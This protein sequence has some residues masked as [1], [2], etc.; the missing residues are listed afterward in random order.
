MASAGERIED[1][2]QIREPRPGRHICDVCDPEHVWRIGMEVAIHQIGGGAFPVIADRRARAS[3]TAD[4]G[5]TCRLHQ[6]LDPLAADMHAAVDQFSVDAWSTI[7]FPGRDMD[8]ADQLHQFPV[9]DVS[10][11]R[12]SHLPGI[13]A[14]ARHAHASCHGLDRISGPVRGLEF[15]DLDGIASFR[16]NQAAALERISLSCRNGLFSRR[17]RR[18]TSRSSLLGMS[19]RLPLSRSACLI[20]V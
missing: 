1:D 10:G 20:H 9:G 12:F 13:E 14:A 18:S 19:A 7:A 2:R 5:Q 17:R 16:A 6:P 15:D 8:L 11:R 3:A 4:A